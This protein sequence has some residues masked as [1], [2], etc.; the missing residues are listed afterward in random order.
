MHKGRDD[1]ASVSAREHT[2]EVLYSASAMLADAAM[3][4]MPYLQH[5]IIPY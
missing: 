3:P 2:S 1:S 5:D 4:K